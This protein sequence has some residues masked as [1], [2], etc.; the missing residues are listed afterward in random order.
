MMKGFIVISTYLCLLFLTACNPN[1]G[2]AKAEA[3]ATATRARCEQQ[4]TETERVALTDG[5]RLKQGRDAKRISKEEAVITANEQFIKSGR[6]LNGVDVVVCETVD[7]WLVN[8]SGAGVEYFVSK[9]SKLE[10]LRYDVREGLT[11]KSDG[12][13]PTCKSGKISRQ[14]AIGI[15]RGAYEK[16]LV[17][18]G[19]T[20]ANAVN[21]VRRY[22]AFACEL[23]DV[24]RIVFEYRELPDQEPPNAHP[25]FYTIDKETG[26]IIQEQ[27][28]W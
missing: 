24:W 1:K 4:L 25:P 7:F 11:V 21:I 12:H 9:H 13:N 8:Y 6:S 20:Q 26:T 19:D 14:E 3:P 10:P 27:L 28:T 15:A 5:F 2:G 16:L 18:H 22:N 23:S 17:N